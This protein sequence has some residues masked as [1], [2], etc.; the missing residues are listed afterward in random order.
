MDAPRATIWVAIIAAIASIIGN[1]LQFG[2]TGKKDT[3]NNTLQKEI[4]NLRSEVTVSE[5]NNRRLRD[6]IAAVNA[7]GHAR[8]KADG[9]TPPPPGPR[10]IDPSPTGSPVLPSPGTPDSLN[11]MEISNGSADAISGVVIHGVSYRNAFFFVKQEITV[12]LHRKYKLLTGKFGIDDRSDGQ[13]QRPVYILSQPGNL[14]LLRATANPNAPAVPFSFDVSNS[15]SIEI[16]DPGGFNGQSSAFIRWV[17]VV[18]IR[19]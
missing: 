6:Q 18:A 11:A 4:E 9:N 1:V 14:P 15:D 17:D 16:G 2:L 7:K 19:K 12:Q 13:G 3:E 5:A 8:P 10:P